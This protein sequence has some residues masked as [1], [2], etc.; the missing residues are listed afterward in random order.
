MV[1]FFLTSSGSEPASPCNPFP[2]G[3]PARPP[4]LVS[5][6]IR[7]SPADRFSWLRQPHHREQLPVCHEGHVGRGIY[8]SSCVPSHT[9]NFTRE[10]M[11][12]HTNQHTLEG[13]RSR[14]EHCSFDAP[15]GKPPLHAAMAELRRTLPGGLL[16]AADR[17]CEALTMPMPPSPTA[18]ITSSSSGKVPRQSE[19]RHLATPGFPPLGSDDHFKLALLGDDSAYRITVFKSGPKQPPCCL[20]VPSGHILCQMGVF[21]CVRNLHGLPHMTLKWQPFAPARGTCHGAESFVFCHYL[22]NALSFA[23]QSS[24]AA[25]QM[26]FPCYPSRSWAVP[27]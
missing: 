27:P 23:V 2:V 24:R 13:K 10:A 8:C 3:V 4:I 6:R 17:P 1:V 16:S 19:A 15:P 7:A 11:G 20:L 26:L 9:G 5:L 22:R 14:G 21:P 18:S 25:P 12:S